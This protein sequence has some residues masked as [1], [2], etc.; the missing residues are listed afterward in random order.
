MPK[1]GGKP[2]A[3]YKPRNLEFQEDDLTPTNMNPKEG[4][5][6]KRVIS[7]VDA[8]MPAILLLVKRELKSA[9]LEGDL[10]QY[11]QTIKNKLMAHMMQTQQWAV[12]LKRPTEPYMLPCIAGDH[13][14][15]VDVI[16]HTDGGVYYKATSPQSPYMP[17]LLKAEYAVC[18]G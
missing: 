13:V 15:I 5:M 8:T 11:F 10:V 1:G 12:V 4:D 18:I 17:G 2:T 3:K 14:K 6:Y 7:M 16:R 9:Y